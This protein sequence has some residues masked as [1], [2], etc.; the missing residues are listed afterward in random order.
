MTAQRP[1]IQ[2]AIQYKDDLPD[3]I[4]VAIIGS[5][6]IGVFAALYLAQS[7]KRV[8]IFE[9]GRIAAEQSSRNWGWI[10]QN[11]RDLD[12]LPIMM[13]ANR[14]WQDINQETNGACG[15]KQIGVSYLTKRKDKAEAL[16]QWVAQATQ[17][18]LDT[19]MISKQD[20]DAQ[21]SGQANET[22]IAGMRTPSDCKGEPFTAVPAVAKLAHETYGVK[23]C[24]DCAVRTI[25]KQ[26]GQVTHIVTEHGAVAC[27]HVVLA[28]G[29]W[30]SLFLRNLG[31]D[32]PQLSVRSTAA[33]TQAEDRPHTRTEAR[34]NVKEPFA[35]G[36]ALDAELAIRPRD[37]GGYS[38]ATTDT[39]DI[40]IGP[41]SFRHLWLYR[42]AIGTIWNSS[43]VFW[44]DLSGYPDSF[45]V[46]RHW[47]SHEISPFERVRVLEPKPSAKKVDEM[48]TRFGRKFPKIG[49][50][51]IKDSWAGL[52]DAMPDFVPIVDHVPDWKGLIVATGMSG[53]GFGIGPGFGEIIAQ[54]VNDQEPEFNLSRFRFSRFTDGSPL[55]LGPSL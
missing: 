17:M 2:T 27:A 36:C 26:A 16:E 32:I 29:A 31:I 14:L 34:N 1:T 11:G 45:F 48:V 22:W 6:V 12:E 39:T 15:V 18:G 10:R 20:I 51:Q 25:E 44:P 43:R 50:P 7:G 38:L 19:H 21:F 4:D 30:S 9:K 33:Q 54:L 23:I 53:H 52:I 24:E 42:K 35:I 13:R 55:R 28:G 47:R 46:K 37:D 41:D 49:K 40:Y 5:G 8:M 3:M